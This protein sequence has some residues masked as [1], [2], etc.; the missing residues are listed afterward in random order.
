MIHLD[1]GRKGVIAV[2]NRRVVLGLLTVSLILGL[3]ACGGFWNT[4]VQLGK[5]IVSDVVVAGASGY[6]LISVADMPDTG[7]ASIQFGTVDVPAI[8]IAGIDKTTIAVQGLTEFMPLAWQFTD[9]SGTLLAANGSTGVVS[10]QI[11]KITFAVTGANPAFT[12]DTTKV[13]LIGWNTSSLNY[14]TNK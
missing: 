4:P 8:A 11:L 2:Q 7:L 5:L 13:T 1:T 10:G 14:Y 12:V 9:T 3:S 6:V